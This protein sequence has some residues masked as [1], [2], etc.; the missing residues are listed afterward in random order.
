MSDNR[1]GFLKKGATLAAMSVAGVGTVMADGRH[2]SE[3]RAAAAMAAA[4]P[5]KSKFKIAVQ[6]NPEPTAESL[7]FYQ[8]MGIDQAVLW[9]D[10][11]KASAEYYTSRKK[12]FAD[13]NI[14]V[15]GF[16]NGDVHNQDKLVLNLPGRDEKI[17]EYKTHLRN[18]GKAGITYTTYAHMGNGIWD[19]D[20]RGVARGGASAR[21]FNVNAPNH[22]RW[23][24]HKYYAPLSHGRKYTRE[25]IWANFKYFIQAV[26]ATA[27]EN[28]VR[29]GIHPDDPPIPE[30]AGVPRLFTSFEG[31]K[32]AL[33][34]A[35][36]S[37]SVGLC[38]CV[39]S[40][41][42]G[43]DK[44]GKDSVGMIDYFGSR[45]R[46]YKIHFRNIYSPLPHFIE[47]FVDDGYTDMYTIMAAL[48]RNNFKGVIIP[49][50]IPNMAGGPNTGTAYSIG[51]MKGLQNRADND[52]AANPKKA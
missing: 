39:G 9:T 5:S 14:N 33:E 45:D 29:I 26:V 51:Y 32:H 41:M 7:A 15:Y 49:D 40:W 24:E 42:E 1:R 13:N 25:E 34:L 44:L 48:K 50:H 18:L 3:V 30:L 47:S 22:G 36:N 28:N 6:A 12:L 2:E 27:E 11:R 38:L 43:G 8:Q 31:Y 46:I 35:H 23:N 52:P 19:S 17:E 37:P 16:G 4:M 10:N 20:T 21:D